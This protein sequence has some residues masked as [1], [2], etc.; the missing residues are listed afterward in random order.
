VS[1]RLDLGV[2]WVLPGRKRPFASTTQATSD[3]IVFL[4]E[5][6]ATFGEVLQAINFDAEASAVVRYFCDHGYADV[7]ANTYVR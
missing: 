2:D 3:L 1:R 5:D 4:A 7:P 6:G